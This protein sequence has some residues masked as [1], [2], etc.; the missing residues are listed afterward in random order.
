MLGVGGND[1][2]NKINYKINVLLSR[3]DILLDVRHL[4]SSLLVH[5]VGDD[6]YGDG[7]D[8]GAV[9]LG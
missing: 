9:V 8:D 6:I 3:L 2:K 7:E 1:D 5:E 4:L